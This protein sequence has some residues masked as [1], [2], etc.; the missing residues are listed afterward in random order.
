MNFVTKARFERSFKQ[1][2][3][4]IALHFMNV[5]VREYFHCIED[6]YFDCLLKVY[7]VYLLRLEDA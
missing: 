6:K 7:S 3:Q 4:F 1:K 2:F 5:Q